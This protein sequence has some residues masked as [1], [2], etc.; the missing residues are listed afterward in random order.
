MSTCPDCT[1]AAQA[2]H[3][4]FTDGCTGCRAR[5]VARGSHYRRCRDAGAQDRAYRQMLQQFGLTHEQVREAAQA[6]YQCQ[7]EAEAAKQRRAA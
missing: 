3:W 2:L 6:D 5:G 1:A 4:R 7:R